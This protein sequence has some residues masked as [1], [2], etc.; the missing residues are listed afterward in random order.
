MKKWLVKYQTYK[1]DVFTEEVSGFDKQSAIS[2]LL[3]C[4]EIYWINKI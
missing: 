4:K 3:N 1:G 2:R